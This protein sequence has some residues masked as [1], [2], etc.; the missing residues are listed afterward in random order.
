MTKRIL[1][2]IRL[3]KIAAVDKPC[4]EHAKVTIMKR[5]VTKAA[6]KTEDGKEFPAS[7]F[8][9]V[10]DPE[11]PS[12]WKLRL[13]SEPGGEPDPRIVGAAAAALGPGFRGQKVE[14][15]DDQR[16]DVIKRV[17]AAWKKANPDK[18]QDEMPEALMMKSDDFVDIIAKM[19]HAFTEHLRREKFQEGSWLLM[20]ALRNSM[21]DAVAAGDMT[22]M[23]QSIEE[24]VSAIRAKFPETE[25]VIKMQIE[26]LK[27]LAEMCDAEK[28]YYKSLGEKGQEA[29]IKSSPDQRAESMKIAKSLDEEIVVN[30]QTI[31]KSAV[32]AGMF[33]VIKSQ[34]KQLSDQQAEITKAQ[35]T[36]EMERLT[37]RA[38]D[39]FGHVP[40]TAAEVAAVLKAVAAMPEDVRKTAEEIMRSAESLAVKSY[41]TKG[42]SGAGSVPG[43][44]TEKLDDMAK[45]HAEVN[46]CDYATAYAEV[47]AKNADLYE[48]SLNEGN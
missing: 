26:T 3:D 41:Q 36:V 9:F 34:Q 25:Q 10:P 17:R 12:T 6:M 38:G 20:N 29:F 39:E 5:Q 48:Q 44:A 30:G 40:G 46:K 28:D 16:D 43:G 8:A 7:D 37:K 14:L 45:K 47:I 24:F 35:A 21:A 15:P 23:R 27:A 33:E 19:G 22:M 13:T 31:K 11:K 32:G 4:Q 1:R 42:H 18:D 2:D